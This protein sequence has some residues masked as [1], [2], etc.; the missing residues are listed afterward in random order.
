[1]LSE[2]GKMILPVPLQIPSPSGRDGWRVF[3][4]ETGSK[5]PI[6]CCE[7]YYMKTNEIAQILLIRLM[8]KPSKWIRYYGLRLATERAKIRKGL[9]V[10]TY[11]MMAGDLVR[12]R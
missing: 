8:K 7:Y 1:M 5:L 9:L 11:Q 10:P 4:G 3:E 12:F 6:P 2:P